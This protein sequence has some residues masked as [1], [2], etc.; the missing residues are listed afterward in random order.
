MSLSVL[1]NSFHF[2]LVKF[3]SDGRDNLRDLLVDGRPG[4]VQGGGL[5][6]DST[7]PH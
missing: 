4:V 7:R 2:F 1:L 6:D 5:E 3:E